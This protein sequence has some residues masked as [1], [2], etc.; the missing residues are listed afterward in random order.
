M[1]DCLKE[2]CDSCEHKYNQNSTHLKSVCSSVATPAGSAHSGCSDF[3]AKDEM[4]K[5]ELL[6]NLGELRYRITPTQLERLWTILQAN[7]AVFAKSKADVG[8]CRLIEHRIDLESDAVPH[9]EGARLMAPWKAEK[10]K[11]EVRQL[12]SLD[13]IESSYSPWDCG[14]VMAKKKGNQL[15][16]CFDF[17]FLNGKTIRDAYPLPRIDENLARLGFAIYFTTLDLGSAFWQ[18]PLREEDR[19]KTAFAGEFR[20]YQ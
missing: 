6:P 15:R 3:P 4:E 16:F 14:I 1:T 9:H 18:V 17:R 11:K 5:L 7:A 12:L 13:F 2:N 10:A 8:K 20:L 19:P